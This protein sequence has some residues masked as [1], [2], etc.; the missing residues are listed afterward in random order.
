LKDKRKNLKLPKD[1]HGKI[2]EATGLT[3]LSIIDYLDSIVSD[4]LSR[5]RAMRKTQPVRVK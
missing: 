1:V 3:G 5:L 4:D 2:K